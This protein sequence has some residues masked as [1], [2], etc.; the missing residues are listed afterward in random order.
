MS[1]QK[2]TPLTQIHTDN[3]AKMVPFAGYKMPIWY[4]SIQQEHLAVRKKTGIFDVSH[5]GLLI[6]SGEGVDDWFQTLSCNSVATARKGKMVYSMMLNNDGGILDDIM[7]GCADDNITL[8]VNASNKAKILE[9]MSKTQPASIKVDDIN[10]THG[11]IAIQGPEAA[12]K[13]TKILNKDFTEFSRF[14]IQHDEINGKNV[15]IMRTGYTGEDGFEIMADAETIQYVWTQCVENDIEPCGLGARDTLRI[16][17]GLPLYGQDLSESITPLMTRYQWVLK[18]DKDFAGK[19]AL[20]AQKESN[21]WTTVG[22]EMIDRVIPRTGYAIEEGGE[23]TSGTMSPLLEKPIAMARVKTDSAEPGTKLHI[24]V[25]GK[26]H[27]AVVV[28]LPF[29]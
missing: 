18:W 10:D 20:E 11:L 9:W 16:E 13:L 3:G 22:I 7:F 8:I 26:R 4:S 24:D 27:D 17:A 23:I 21:D 12:V 14:S 15:T 5:M 2:S 1:N 25:R 29:I 6:L 19:A 28:E